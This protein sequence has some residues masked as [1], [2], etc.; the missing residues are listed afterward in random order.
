MQVLLALEEIQRFVDAVHTNIR[1]AVRFHAETTIVAARRFETD[2]CLFISSKAAISQQEKAFAR[3]RRVAA[4]LD[5]IFGADGSH[6]QQQR[7][8]QRNSG[9]ESQHAGTG[10]WERK[11]SR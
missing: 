8:Q 1:A 7:Q 5:R 11:F 2:H 9:A 4:R 10:H 6:W 3:D